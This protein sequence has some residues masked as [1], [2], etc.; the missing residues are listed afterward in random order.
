MT[1]LELY[2]EFVSNHPE[3]TKTNYKKRAKRFGLTIE[4][5]KAVHGKNELPKSLE[6]INNP[7]MKALAKSFYEGYIDY[8]TFIKALVE[9]QNDIKSGI[10]AADFNWLLLSD[11]HIP[12]DDERLFDWVVGLAKKYGIDKIVQTGDLIDHYNLSFHDKNPNA[13]SQIEEFNKTMKGL[14]KWKQA[15]PEMVVVKGNHSGRFDRRAA[16]AGL[17]DKFVRPIEEVYEF[18]VG[19]GK[20]VT[21]FETDEFVV[22]H[23]DD[24]GNIMNKVLRMQKSYVQG[25]YHSKTYLNFAT[26]KLWGMQLGFIAD[27]K[28][29]A[30]EYAGKGAKHM[31]H[32]V[33]L[34][35]EGNP[36]I[37][38]NKN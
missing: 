24:G 27:K 35:I 20:M 17:S 7:E 9:A 5:V 6:S 10:R 22:G 30:M 1:N 34:L 28:S 36:I 14:E 2:K 3:Y 4:E 8:P 32:S 23:G 25:H 16:Y 33:G 19:W 31:I 15:F 29:L 21:E 38:T 11:I 12:F 37:L 18:P 13:L 26:E